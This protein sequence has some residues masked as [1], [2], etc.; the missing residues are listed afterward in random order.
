MTEITIKSADGGSFSAYL[1]TP[2]AGKGPGLLVIQEIFGVNAAMRAI[3]DEFAAKGFTALCPD[4][5]WRQQPG[6]QLTDKTEA[7]WGRAFELYKGFD[8]EKGISDLKSALSILRSLPSVSGK[9]G[10][11]GF[12]LGGRLAY[13]M[14]TRSD[15]D[16]SVGYYGV[17][18]QNNLAE[19]VSIT[20]P[21]LLHIAEKDEYCPPE[22]Q[23]QIKAGLAENGLAT[24]ATYPG[25]N[26]AFAR[27]NGQNFNAA[28]ADAANERT[29]AFFKEHLAG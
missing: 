20:H 17:G 16:A 1:A 26:H 13:L 12:C 8:E 10:T 22:A 29:F 6:L 11:V 25:V 19:A 24:I 2:P 7:E 15:I 9:A 14:A 23:L 4:L 3:T 5:F 27:P 18:I 28:A 21:L